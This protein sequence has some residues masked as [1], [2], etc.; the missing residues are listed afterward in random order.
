[1]LNVVVNLQIK[2]DQ[3][4][5]VIELFKKL[6]DATKKEEGCVKYE[7]VQDLQNP[8]TL[9]IL[10]QWKTQED[11]QKHSQTEHYT[12]IL[13]QM[14]QYGTKEPQISVCTNVA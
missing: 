8:T 5:T 10:E 2:E 7:M 3:I 1:M 6:A 11:L 12:T 13:P 9:I 14:V 4:H